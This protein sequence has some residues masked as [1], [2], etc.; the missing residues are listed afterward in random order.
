MIIDKQH[1]LGPSCQP[2][3]AV[4]YLLLFLTNFIENRD[5]V[6]VIFTDFKKA[7]HTVHHDLLIRELETLVGDSLHS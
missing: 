5:L 3:L 6:Y 4:L 1:E 2:L 7:F